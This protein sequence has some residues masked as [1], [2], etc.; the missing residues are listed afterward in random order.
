MSSEQKPKRL[1][2]LAE[3]KNKVGLSRST[4]YLRI[5]RGTFP[6]PISIGGGR[7]AWLESEV[8][9]WIDNAIN[10]SRHPD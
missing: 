2:R 8:D 6:T 5:E 4:I 9:E 3:V 7:V 10:E 1:I